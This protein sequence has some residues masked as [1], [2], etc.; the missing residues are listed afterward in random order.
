MRVLFTSGPLF[1]HVNTLMP[2]ALAAQ[3]AGHEVVLA[4]G[5]DL[6][7]HVERHG[8]A[9]WRVGMTHAQGGGSR[10]A[11]WFDYFVAGARS[12]VPDLVARASAW[13]PD[14]VIHEET[15]LAGA[16]V[17]AVTGA[18]QVT[19]GLGLMPPKALIEQLVGRLDP[20]TAG[21]GVPGLV[22]C[23]GLATYLHVCPPALHDGGEA[24]WQQVLP[25]QPSAGLAQPGESLPEAIAALP[26]ERTVHLTLGTVFH[27]QEAV[28]A[29]ALAAIGEL[30]LNVVATTGPGTDPARF[31]PQPPHVYLA[32]YLPHA[33]LLPHCDVVVSHGGAGAMFGALRH[34]LPQLLLPQGADQ[35]MNA[36]RCSGAG[37]ALAL[38]GEQVTVPAIRAG[39][40]RLLD[41]PAFASS[42]RRVGAQLRAMPP[43]EEVVA[44]L[45]G[46]PG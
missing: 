19:H 12:R 13:R 16:V 26:F 29:S 35:F 31:G 43:P 17:A 33:L 28:L 11:S 21:W 39:V 30:S 46:L 36:A 8:I 14:V 1:G 37:V 10:Q 32:P 2:L 44:R 38:V 5:A 27:F 40:R 41:E 34:G 9:A 18:R 23:M 4:T 25:L 6:A 15:E 22:R 45:L 42:A 24:A 7:P 20:F 3:R